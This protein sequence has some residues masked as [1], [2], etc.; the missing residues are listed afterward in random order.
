MAFSYKYPRPAITVDTVALKITAE[1]DLVLL[2]TR[3][4]APFEGCWALPGGFVDM[5]ELLVD[6]AHRELREETGLQGLDLTQFHAFD[7]IGRDPRQRTIS[8]VFIAYMQ[9]EQTIKA[10]DDAI[11]ASWFPLN[12]L[13]MLAFD[14]ADVLEKVKN[15]IENHR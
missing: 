10:G 1:H 12:Q 14:H 9:H 13:P 4:Q 8:I 15:H 11:A 5:N 2:I 7:A 6:A 3:G